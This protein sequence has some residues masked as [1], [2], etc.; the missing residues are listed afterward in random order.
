MK[1]L[2]RSGAFGRGSQR[3]SLRLVE[4]NF[5][6]VAVAKTSSPCRYIPRTDL[7]K[8]RDQKNSNRPWVCIYYQARRISRDQVAAEIAAA[9]REIAAAIATKKLT[10]IAAAK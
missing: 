4:H 3:L 1:L 10:A 8:L 2:E 7:T 9:I 6:K 5:A